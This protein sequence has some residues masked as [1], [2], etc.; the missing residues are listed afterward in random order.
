MNLAFGAVTEL[1]ARQAGRALL[2]AAHPLPL[3]AIHALLDECR[4]YG[5]LPFSIL[6]RH[7]FIAES[8]LRTAVTRGALPPERLRDFKLSIK[9]ISGQTST[10]F[11]EV[12][13]GQRD[14]LGFMRT[15][16]HLRPGSYDI[17]S[18]RYVDREDL[19]GDAQAL[20]PTEKTERHFRLN[21]EEERNLRRLL[22]ESGLSVSPHTSDAH[23]QK[24]CR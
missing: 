1:R 5:T 14:A 15:Y 12:C 20:S 3:S 13:K 8:L 10:D 6:A 9:T 19:F 18:P 4:T 2:N 23:R 11:L 22:A 17:L 16:G 7:G 21:G 24:H